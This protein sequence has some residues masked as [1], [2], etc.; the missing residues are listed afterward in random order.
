[1]SN[2]NNSEIIKTIFNKSVRSK[3]IHEAVLLVEDGK[4]DFSEFISYGERTIDSPIFTASI[5]KLYTTSCILILESQNKLSLN[6]PIDKYLDNS[7][8]EGLHIYKGIDY[9]KKITISNLLFQTSGI[10]DWFEES[11]GRK[12]MIDDDV[13]LSFEEKINNIK[14]IS[15]Y[16]APNTKTRYSD[17][18][19]LLLGKIIEKITEKSLAAACDDFLFKPLNLKNTYLITKENNIVPDIYY[20]DKKINRPNALIS[21]SESGDAITTI[22]ELMTFLKAFFN[23]KF[24]PKS[25]FE[26]LNKYGK[27]QITMGPIYYGGGY[28]QIPLNSPYTLFMGKGELLGHMGATSSIAFYYPDK[29]LYFVGDF[30]Q[31]ANPT[32]SIMTTMKLAMKLK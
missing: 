18:N 32:V 11:N 21:A 3:A 31:L 5:G 8:M 10:P 28:M 19:F 25:N 16:F 4:G 1:M 20:K 14:K 12:I 9:S 29:D 7:I 13:N 23:D 17:T 27:L 15:P 26:R 24:F 6:D 22:K 30:N 2:I